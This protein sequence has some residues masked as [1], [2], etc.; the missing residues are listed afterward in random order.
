M[1]PR[2]AILRMK[3]KKRIFYHHGLT[4][5]FMD[6]W[7]KYN[8]ILYKRNSMPEQVNLNKQIVEEKRKKRLQL[9]ITDKSKNFTPAEQER[10]E[11]LFITLD[12]GKS[13]SFSVKMDQARYESNGIRFPKKLKSLSNSVS[14]SVSPDL[15]R[16]KAKFVIPA[17]PYL[18]IDA[19]TNTS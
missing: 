7:L 15:S 16:N 14:I 2:S 12:Q 5:R 10:K 9:I 3:P 18:K 1:E 4:L 17:T 19:D 6:P 13:E 8:G 11:S